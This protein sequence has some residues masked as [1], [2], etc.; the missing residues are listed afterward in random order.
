MCCWNHWNPLFCLLI[1]SPRLPRKSS[2]SWGSHSFTS[3]FCRLNHQFS[4]GTEQLVKSPVLLVHSLC[5][6]KGW[7]VLVG[8][9]LIHQYQ[10][11]KSNNK[12]PL[13]NVLYKLF[14]E[15]WGMSSTS[16]LLY[17]SHGFNYWHIG[18]DYPQLHTYNTGFSTI[19]P[20]FIINQQQKAVNNHQ[21]II[22]T[23][24]HY[25][26]LLHI[27]WFQRN[28]WCDFKHLIFTNGF[29]NMYIY[30]YTYVKLSKATGRIHHP[31]FCHVY[32]WL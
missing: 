7:A 25:P 21:Q 31:Q 23:V 13:G 1:H 28:M 27:F 20:Q 24:I 19:N 16:H 9:V 11:G 6:L 17:K 30:I 5:L 10:C 15:Q 29:Q 14:V 18:Y 26:P 32:R 8:W 12:P 2:C 22:W 3:P 4:L